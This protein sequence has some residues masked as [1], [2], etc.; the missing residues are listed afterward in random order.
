MAEIS[1]WEDT[2]TSDLSPDHPT[3]IATGIALRGMKKHL[4]PETSPKVLVAGAGFA[5]YFWLAMWPGSG[6]LTLIDKNPY[7]AEYL[8][9]CSAFLQQRD[10]TILEGAVNDLPPKPNSYNVIHA[11]NLLHYLEYEEGTSFL[12]LVPRILPERSEDRLFIFQ[13]IAVADQTE[14]S[15]VLVEGLKNDCGLNTVER[16]VD[17]TSDGFL[18]TLFTS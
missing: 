1:A 2:R 18:L 6:T 3:T 15:D 12:K 11:G 5:G 4:S 8:A 13:Q 9:S 17:Q 7:M 14:D 16:S 10:A